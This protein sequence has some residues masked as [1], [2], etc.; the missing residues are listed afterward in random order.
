MEADLPPDSPLREPQA[1]ALAE[2]RRLN[3]TVSDALRVARSG[4]VRVGTIDLR[5]PLSAAVDAALPRFQERGAILDSNL[6]N[7]PVSMEGDPDAL[8]QLFLNLFLNAAEA[9]E[10][11]GT[12]S[13]QIVSRESDVSVRIRD[14]G[15]GMPPEVRERV[16]EPLFSTRAEGTGLGLPI[17]RR[18]A[19]AHGGE[20]RIESASGSG[21]TVEVRLPRSVPRGGVSAD[22]DPA[23]HPRLGP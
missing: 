6:G 13:V 9:L 8:E 20:I 16:F 1:K 22:T 2:V 21:T 3:A 19:V 10:K 23:A 18:I 14:D 15:L 7:A 5:E 17:A 12:A 11:E 4:Q